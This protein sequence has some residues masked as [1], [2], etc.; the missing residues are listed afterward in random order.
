[1][2]DGIH[3]VFRV[4]PDD[5]GTGHAGY[6]FSADGGR[7]WQTRIYADGIQSRPDILEYGGKPTVVYNYKSDR[8]VG[9]FPPMHNSRTAIKMVRDGR[10]ILD[11]FSKYGIVEHETV[12]VC[13]DLYMT[14]SNCPQALSTEN[15]A[16]WI[17]EGRPVEQGKEAIEWMRLGNLL[18]R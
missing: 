1:M 18:E 13:G 15:G 7:T 10:V 4:P 14:F 6:T 16:A 17:E 9:N 2:D 8:P 11:L 12:S 3:G 5:H